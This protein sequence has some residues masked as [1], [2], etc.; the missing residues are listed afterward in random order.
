MDIY[1]DIKN[2]KEKLLKLSDKRHKNMHAF[3]V[4]TT[5][6]E[7]IHREKSFHIANTKEV[8]TIKRSEQR[9]KIKTQ[10]QH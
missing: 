4:H 3:V 7:Q 2:E 6:L 1:K 8:L 9:I 10:Q 5:L